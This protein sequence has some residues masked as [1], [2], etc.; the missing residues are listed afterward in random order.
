MGAGRNGLGFAVLLA[1]VVGLA[2]ASGWE[3]LVNVVYLLVGVLALGLVW[4]RVGLAGLELTRRPSA[5]RLQVG[6]ELVER[7]TLRSRGPL[8]LLPLELRDGSTLPGRERLRVL[9]VPPFGGGAWTV[10]TLCRQRGAYTLG[11]TELATSDPFGCF[12][13]RRVLATHRSLLVLPATE[14]LPRFLPGGRDLPGGAVTQPTGRHDAAQSSSVRDYVPGDPLSR[15]H[16]PS[17]A[18]SGRLIV[19]QLE[20]EP[21][22]DVWI[23]LDMH[24][25][26]QRGLGEGSTEEAAVRAAAS[27]ARRFVEA[28]RAVGLWAQ[29]DRAVAL[30]P[31]RGEAQLG[32]LLEELATLRAH[33]ALPFDELLAGGEA[34]PSRGA[35]LIAI[36]PSIEADWPDALVEAG[37]GGRPIAILV[38]PSTFGGRESSLVTIGRLAAG[39]VPTYLV[40]RAVPLG[41][42]LVA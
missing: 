8:P 20:H 39:G 1:V 10:R 40:K 7:F 28:G 21:T 6:E 4:G 22:A 41:E 13:A 19:K 9:A 3:L 18:R 12:R 26:P 14:P 32:R 30:S 23:A 24:A 27:V 29:G 16:W 34:R 38:E 36:T 31:D 11:P 25:V 5:D 17:T 2:V 35:L 15:I 37:R 33:G 42:T